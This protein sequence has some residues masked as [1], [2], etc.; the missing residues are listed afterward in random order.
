MIII[1]RGKLSFYSG[2]VV[3][4]HKSKIVHIMWIVSHTDGSTDMSS[5]ESRIGIQIQDRG[6]SQG[7]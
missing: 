1:V 5:E 4:E 3:F 6:N 2:T 7:P